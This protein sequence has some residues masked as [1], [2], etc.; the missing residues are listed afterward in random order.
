[1]IV[2]P[3]KNKQVKIK[4]KETNLLDFDSGNSSF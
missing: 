2:N 1:M 4:K 3:K